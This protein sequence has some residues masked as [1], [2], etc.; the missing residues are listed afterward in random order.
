MSQPTASALR[1]AAE[2]L[3]E[4]EAAIMTWYRDLAAAGT[5]ERETPNIVMVM[6]ALGRHLARASALVDHAAR[7]DD[8][9]DQPF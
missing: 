2:E 3:Q 1:Q 6:T 9:R 8:D 4:A 5:G 7:L